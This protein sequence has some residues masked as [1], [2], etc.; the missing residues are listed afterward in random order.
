M[1]LKSCK[2][3][4]LLRAQEKQA[5]LLGVGWQ[6]LELREGEF[7]GAHVHQDLQAPGT[8]LGIL[9]HHF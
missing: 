4:A 1:S 7:H 8:D 6:V 9:L 5:V 2:S 3:V